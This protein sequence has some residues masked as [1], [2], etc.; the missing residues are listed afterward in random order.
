MS[1]K[2]LARKGTPSGK[3]LRVQRIYLQRRA[4]P[5]LGHILGRKPSSSKTSLHLRSTSGQLQRQIILLPPGKSIRFDNFSTIPT[6]KTAKAT[7][8]HSPVNDALISMVDKEVVSQLRLLAPR[9]RG[10]VD[11]SFE[12]I[13]Y[14]YALA[15]ILKTNADEWQRFAM[16]AEWKRRRKRPRAFESDASEALMHVMRFLFGPGPAAAG[17]IKRAMTLLAGRWQDQV[18]ARVLYEYLT[19]EPPLKTKRSKPIS[20]SL[21]DTVASRDML[22]LGESVSIWVKVSVSPSG[23]RGK[24]LVEIHEIDLNR[25]SPVKAL[26][27]TD[28]A[29]QTTRPD[30]IR[31]HPDITLLRQP[32]RTGYRHDQ[33]HG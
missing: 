5:K 22:K 26:C 18:S 13:T 30:D 24:P 2:C 14:A 9:F 29:P 8:R 6:E 7:E 12:N 16:A 4:R 20:V 19:R 10:S 17:H 1:T 32:N 21:T 33:H 27:N 25:V 31:W 11:P 3:K 15:S 28:N 23:T